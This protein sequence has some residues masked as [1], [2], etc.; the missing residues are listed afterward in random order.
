MKCQVLSHEFNIAESGNIFCKLEVRPAGDEWAS[1]FNYVMFVT[2]AMQA[3]LEAKFPSYIYLEEVRVPA[4][5]KFY[6]T[7]ATDGPNYSAGEFVCTRDKEGNEVPIEFTDI[8]VVIRTMPDGKPSRGED[9]QKLF[10]RNWRRGIVDGTII[11][12]SAYADEEG[13][14]AA[15]TATGDPF[16]GAESADEGEVG[17]EAAPTTGTTAQPTQ[18]NTSQQRPGNARP[19]VTVRR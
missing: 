4:P 15:P 17:G 12:L 6:R 11:P 5:E 10:D 14:T 16:E 2:E 19:G 18:Q 9:A 13:S 3:A 7:W 8:K 1:S